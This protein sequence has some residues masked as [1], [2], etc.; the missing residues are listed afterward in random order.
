MLNDI[1]LQ[2]RHWQTEDLKAKKCVNIS[3]KIIYQ[4]IDGR[5]CKNIIVNK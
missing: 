5:K 2:V 1:G 3:V 4:K